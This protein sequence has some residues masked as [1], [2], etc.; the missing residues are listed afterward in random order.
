LAEP[1]DSGMNDC[2]CETDI[3]HINSALRDLQHKVDDLLGR[4][5]ELEGQLQDERVRSRA[6][7]GRID[8]NEINGSSRG[9]S[10]VSS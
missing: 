10:W 8:T 9:F 4:I 5:V 6:L 7:S 3:Y 2:G 1:E